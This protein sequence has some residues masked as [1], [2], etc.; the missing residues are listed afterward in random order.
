MFWLT[1]C[2]G[3]YGVTPGT[4]GNPT[5]KASISNH[6]ATLTLI[7]GL[8]SEGN[9][10]FEIFSEDA[11]IYKVMYAPNFYDLDSEQFHRIMVQEKLNGSYV[12]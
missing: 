6:S 10:T 12:L 3:R 5:V 7:S 4:A 9:Y 8:V 2:G 11:I 1:K